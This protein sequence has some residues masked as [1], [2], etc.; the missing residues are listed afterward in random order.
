MEIKGYR[1]GVA[2]VTALVLT[3]V[4]TIVLGGVIG[5]V[6]HASRMAGYYEGK[7]ACRLA[8][9]SEIEVAKAA[10]HHQFEYSL[11]RTARIVAAGSTA[12]GSYDWFD[13]YS[14]AKPKRNI[15]KVVG[16]KDATLTLANVVTNNG[17][18]VKVRIGRVDHPTGAQWANVT[19][20]AEATRSGRGGAVA[21]TIIEE[22]EKAKKILGI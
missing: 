8:A 13:A 4:S 1:K 12:P 3:G 15:G 22:T 20:V 10:I 2:L 16:G 14:G 21:K 9:Q 17:C 18:L 19:L 6:S 7:N 5:Y 11:N